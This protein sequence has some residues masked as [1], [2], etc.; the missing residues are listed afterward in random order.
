MQLARLFTY[1]DW[2]NRL[3][4]EHLRSASTPKALSLLAHIVGAQ[5]TWYARLR[6]EK[7]RTPVWPELTL[8]DC[9]RSLDLLRGH[10]AEYLDTAP[11]EETLSYTNSKGEPWS[12]RIEDVLMHVVIHG[13]Y[14]RGQIATVLRGAEM[15][16]AYTDF[17]HCT[18]AGLIG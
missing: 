17:I 12:S 6:N 3:E 13:A 2:A 7:P 11:L 10:W 15:V 16:P 18:R 1:D 4:V 8:D 9:E 14:H 5:W